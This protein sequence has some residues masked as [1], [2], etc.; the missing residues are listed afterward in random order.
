MGITNLEGAMAEAG[1]QE[2]ET[3]VTRLHNK[4]VN[5]IVTGTM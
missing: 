5:Y 1:L 4:I 3:Y 2:V